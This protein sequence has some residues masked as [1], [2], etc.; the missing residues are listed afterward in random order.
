MWVGN[1][2]D[3]EYKKTEYQFLHC[4]HEINVSTKPIDLLNKY[5]KYFVLRFLFVKNILYITFCVMFC[6]MI[7]NI[8]C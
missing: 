7:Y 4:L 3:T 5:L 6:L 8:F 1:E 2:T